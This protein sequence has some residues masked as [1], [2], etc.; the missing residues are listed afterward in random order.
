LKI[1]EVRS[2]FTVYIIASELNRLDGI[3]ESLGLAGYMCASFTELTA[4]FSEFAS[5]PPHM[6]LLDGEEATFDLSKV[7]RQVGAQLP[8][9]HI[10]IISP[11]E[12]RERNLPFLDKGAYD[13][14]YTPVK[15]TTELLKK[16]DRAA[17]RDYFMYLNERLSKDGKVPDAGGG[18][19]RFARD[20]FSQR[21]S[22][23]CVQVF[24]NVLSAELGCS[25]VFFR[26]IANR[27]VLMASQAYKVEADWTGIGVNFNETGE[28]FRATHLREP[29]KIPEFKNM[30][31]EVFQATEFF[32]LPVEAMGEI[33]G[34]AAFLSSTPDGA[35]VEVAGDYLMLLNRALS[36]LEAER[37]LHVATVKDPA[38]DLINRQNFVSR[39]TQEISRSR[40]T[41]A[42]V[43]LVVLALDQYGAISTQI[44]TEEAQTVMRMAARIFEKHSRVND[45]VGRT[46]TDEF[47][48][49]LP[50]TGRQGALIKAERLR[51]IIESADF[52]RVIKM[53][54]QLTVSVGVAEYPSMVRDADELMASA[55]EALFQVRGQGNK[56]CVA[57][58]PDGFVADFQVKDKGL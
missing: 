56:T 42:P 29:D 26:F 37:R 35:P 41:M 49:L 39:V 46:G 21:S 12:H 7:V 16:L 17:E 55:D 45:V 50:H 47:G 53:F 23:D 10:F 4:A 11:L 18:N 31:K 52:S 43:S 40:R 28:G 58:P 30:M 14:I 22:D 32:A 15:S 9:S 8:E 20:L 48:I 27:R 51:R 33:Q 5:N 57:K 6:V 24:L 3:S 13:L 54:P 44:G 2:S 38:T 19:L 34:V 25:S 1:E 36:L